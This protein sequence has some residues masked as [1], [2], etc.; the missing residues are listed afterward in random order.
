[1]GQVCRACSTYG[2]GVLSFCWKTGQEENL[3]DQGIDGMIIL[4][5]ILKHLDGGC[6]WV[7]LSRDGD[8]WLL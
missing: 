7:R 2:L 8:K 6:D 1:M 5:C 3:E 4:T